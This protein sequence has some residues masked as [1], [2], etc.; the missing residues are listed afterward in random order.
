MAAAAAGGG[1]TLS[2]FITTP[3]PSTVISHPP[4]LPTRLLSLF[5]GGWQILCRLDR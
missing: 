1:V 3:L 5:I 2:N 4:A